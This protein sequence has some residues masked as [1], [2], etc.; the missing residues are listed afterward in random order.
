M[1]MSSS[2]KSG[3]LQQILADGRKHWDHENYDPNARRRFQEALQCKTPA[4]GR[5]LYRSPTEEQEFANTC[6]SPACTSCGHAGMMHW[7]RQRWCALPE[8][9]YCVITFTMPAQLW[10]LFAAN[11]RL[12]K[13]IAE[14]AGRVILS[15]GRVHRGIELGV[16]PVLQ[17]FNGKLDFNPH[18]HALV[19]ASDL[20]L[21]R[22]GK[23]SF[24]LDA[25][26][27][28]RSWQKL[29][30]TLLHEALVKDKSG[31][32]QKVIDG[33]A[34]SFWMPAD[35]RRLFGKK[36]FLFYA[37]RYVR[38][39]PIASRR[40]IRVA[41]GRVHFWYKDKRS[42]TT[43]SLVYTLEEFTDRWSQQLP[44]RY[45]HSVRYFGLFAPRIW[46]LIA[47]TVFAVLGEKPRRR[48]NRLPWAAAIEKQ[49][50]R[51]PLL[52][53]KGELM[54]FIRHLPPVI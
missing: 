48:P 46:G 38:R 25:K 35:V 27:L 34:C 53:E 14:I 50:G 5:R 29:V 2:P 52:D 7:R 22:F 39:P 47:G 4:L 51:N 10:P 20:R 45:Q 49:Y 32:V 28:G 8:G 43:K 31:S 36:H 37:G 21:S 16:L 19:T 1:S 18:V 11:P 6:K 44:Q 26:K 17:T 15:Y 40:I 41:N 30:V 13:K 12:C 33:A 54:R 3:V 42:K 9:S 24:F 23:T